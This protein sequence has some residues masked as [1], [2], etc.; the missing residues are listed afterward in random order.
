M[1][2]W[3]HLN[4]EFGS[5][6][7]LFIHLIGIIPSFNNS[8]TLRY[9]S[10]VPPYG[11]NPSHPI[12]TTISFSSWSNQESNSQPKILRHGTCQTMNARLCL[13]FQFLWL[14]V[15]EN[16]NMT[17]T[18]CFIASN[19]CLYTMEKSFGCNVFLLNIE[20][21]TSKLHKV[22]L[23]SLKFGPEIPHLNPLQNCLSRSSIAL[24]PHN[25]STQFLLANAPNSTTNHV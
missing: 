18:L 14:W 13:P 17:P 6:S 11:E 10:L 15:K 8:K 22:D 2:P 16:K 21:H 12:C 24:P 25:A 9:K 7:P 23:V 4:R 1:K 20:S 3:Q 19:Y 5:D